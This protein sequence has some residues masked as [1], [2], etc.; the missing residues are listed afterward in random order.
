[1][2][3]FNKTHVRCINV[4]VHH[5]VRCIMCQRNPRAMYHMSMQHMCDVSCINSTHVRCIII[6]TIIKLLLSYS[7]AI[8]TVLG[9]FTQKEKLSFSLKQFKESVPSFVS[10]QHMCDISMSQFNT[11]AMYHVSMQHMCDIS[12]CQFNRCAMYHVS[13][14]HICDVSCVKATHVRCTMCQLNKCVMYHA[15]IQQM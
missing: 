3:Q 5:H 2:C 8:T 9:Y 10:M 13:I 11:C 4:S 6:I 7:R 15:S 1:M 12:M 14:Q